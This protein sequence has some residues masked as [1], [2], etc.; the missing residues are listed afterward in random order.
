[1]RVEHG[2]ERACGWSNR[3]V[4]LETDG[5]QVW[6]HVRTLLVF[7]VALLPVLAYIAEIGR[8]RKVAY[9]LTDVQLE[10]ERLVKEERELVA[11]RARLESLR[12]IETWALGDRGLRPP[13]PEQVVVVRDARP[14][15]ATWLAR[16][17]NRNE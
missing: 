6:S 14:G 13:D 17:R 15:E 11:E 3:P 16:G 4:V 1:V 10:Y 7:A 8:T 5:R 2:S 12:E 9:E